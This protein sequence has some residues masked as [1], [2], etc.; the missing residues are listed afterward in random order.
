VLPYEGYFE[1]LAKILHPTRFGEQFYAMMYGCYLDESFDMK[2]SGFYAVGGFIAKGVPTFEL[3]RNW[4]KCLKRHGL[5]YYKA[6]QCESGTGQFAKFV[7]NPKKITDA[8]RKTL[9]SISHEFCRIIG[10]PVEY[11]ERNF[12]ALFGAGVVQNDFYDVIKEPTARAV[13]GDSPYRLAYDLGMVQAAWAMKELS[14]GTPKHCV[15]FVCDEDE[16]HVDT[17]PCAYRAL[18]KANPVAAQYMCTFSTA[19]EKLCAPLQAADAV[20]YEIRKVLKYSKR[21]YETKLREQ[22][23]MFADARVMFYVGHTERVQ[24]EWIVANH[25]PAEPFKIDELMKMEITKNIDT[26]RI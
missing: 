18:K 26:L 12:L 13:L 9:D 19:D 5:D 7:S 1:Q 6:S 20:V 2:K 15:S 22:F 11:D 25:K 17:A 3:E 10:F 8:E 24:L 21:D 4:E 14:D 16:E 23:G